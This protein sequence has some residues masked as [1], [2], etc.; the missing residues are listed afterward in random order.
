[1]SGV[2]ED[3]DGALHHGVLAHEQH[4]VAAQALPDALELPRPHVVG[5]HHQD[6]RELSQKPP[7]LLVVLALLRRTTHTRL[8]SHRRDSQK[9]TSEQEREREREKWDV[10]VLLFSFLPEMETLKALIYCSVWSYGHRRCKL[11]A[12]YFIL[13]LFLLIKWERIGLFV[14]WPTIFVLI[15]HVCDHVGLKNPMGTVSCSISCVFYVLANENDK[16]AIIS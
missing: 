14:S 6:L 16:N 2:S 9:V 5:A 10:E 15:G 3:V 13:F 12:F 7:E 8:H 11:H 1:M 4:R